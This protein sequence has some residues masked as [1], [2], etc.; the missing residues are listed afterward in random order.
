MLVA[1]ECIFKITISSLSLSI[2]LLRIFDAPKV[3]A[4][5]AVLVLNHN[6]YLL[7]EWGGESQGNN[8]IGQA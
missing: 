2:L 8:L 4:S 6:P 3:A 5:T 1:T 7:D